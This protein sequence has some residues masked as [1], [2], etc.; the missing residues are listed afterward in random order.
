MTSGLRSCLRIAWR[1][2]RLFWVLWIA[3]LSLSMPAT[4]TQYDTLFPP[5][6]NPQR[7]IA[8][9]AGNPS[10]RAML[11]PAYDLT[12]KGGFVFWRVGGF[13]AVMAAMMAGFGII[14]A[15]RAE[16]EDGRVELVRSGPVGAHDP[17][18]AAVTL[19]L[20]GCAG[21]GAVNTLAVGALGLPWA[22][23]VAAGLAIGLTGAIFVGLGA[24]V[25]QLFDSARAAR[26]WTVG[27]GLGGMYL[28]RA[29]VDG[30]GDGSEVAALRWAI[31]LEW[32][33][34]S[35]PY[36]DERW[37]VLLLPLALTIV[38]V[39]MAYAVESRRD[40]GAGLRDSRP[41]P[42]DGPR[43]L[44]GA[45]GLAWRLQRVGLISWTVGL[46]VCAV[47]FGSIATQVDRLASDSSAALHTIEKLGGHGAITIAFFT[48]ML[49][50]LVSI[51]G[52]M[53]V[54][55]I[56]RLRIEESA[57]HTEMLLS[58]ASS[59]TAVALSHLAWAVGLPSLVLVLIGALLPVAKAVHD[60]SARSLVVDFTRGAAG[61]VPGLVLVAGFAMLV[62]GWQPRLMPAVWGLLGWSLFTMWFSVLFDLPRW[63]IDLQPW[64]H[65]A[66][67]PRDP[68]A[69]TPFLVELLAGA[70]LLAAG[71]I[72]YQRRDIVGR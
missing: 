48:A 67:V 33:M 70:L 43:N 26:A 19:S 46:L 24:L 59:R 64:G 4:I 66:F 23:S 42:A 2:N 36:S 55:T 11:G 72:G 18:T 28:L 17:L 38:L 10:M 9:L 31:P 57:G 32:G 37:W 13:T 14:R 34:M 44:S 22:G 62:I 40:H 56:N 54:T 25:A 27:I 50:I 47:L 7:T 51:V 49:S 45:W 5:G 16:E 60:A 65:L 29:I 58:T 69:W 21:L 41:G 39:A 61:L 52:F 6:S 30:G 8:L 3:G 53:A 35:R 15:T 12:T 71:V 68:M 63:L 20:L 1:R